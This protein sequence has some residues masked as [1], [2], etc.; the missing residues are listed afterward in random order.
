MQKRM[1]LLF[2]RL[3]QSVIIFKRK[4]FSLIQESLVGCDLFGFS[5]L[6][7]VSEFNL[8]DAPIVSNF[9]LI[10]AL[11]KLEGDQKEKLISL[12]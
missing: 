1:M 5:D 11:N 4:R 3:W 9:D 2:V 6:V 7:T 10:G 12:L 8:M